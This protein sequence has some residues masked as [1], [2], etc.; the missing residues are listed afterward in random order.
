MSDGNSRRYLILLLAQ[1]LCAIVVLANVRGIFLLLIDNI[2][3]IM[4][5]T[6]GSALQTALAVLIGQA[7]Y[8]WRLRHVTIPATYGGLVIGHF[9]SFAARIGFI[10]GGALFSLYYLRHVPELDLGYLDLSWRGALLIAVIFALYCYTLEL[11]RLGNAMQIRAMQ[12]KG[13]SRA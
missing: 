1:T 5:A 13:D 6:R 2:G 10:F 12:A 8:W 9:V 7:C 3:T 4:T 11:E